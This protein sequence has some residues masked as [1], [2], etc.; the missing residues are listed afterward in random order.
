MPV[1][2]AT[3][4]DRTPEGFVALRTLRGAAK[5]LSFD[6]FLAQYPVPVLHVVDIKVGAASGNP[7]AT[8]QPGLQLRAVMSPGR[9]AFRY[10]DE[11]AFLAKRA[12]G[13]AGATVSLG[14]APENDVVLA[15]ESI[16]QLHARFTLEGE[17][18]LV[19]DAGSRNG[20]T[21]NGE[22]LPEGQPLPLESGD[23][24]LFGGE[25]AAVFL[26]PEALYEKARR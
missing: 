12:H 25:I 26:T 17:R 5:A 23:K 6:A 3:I 2:H 8:V 24:L 16:S 4:P 15:V 7:D 14:R 13:S 10:L 21:R 22:P 19:T 1:R 18:W 11:V 9:S 20:T